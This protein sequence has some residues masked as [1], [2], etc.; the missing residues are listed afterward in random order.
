[1]KTLLTMLLF[2]SSLQVA[3][4][5]EDMYGMYDKDGK[6]RKMIEQ[7]ERMRQRSE[8]AENDEHDKKMRILVVSL[9]I[10]LVPVVVVGRMVVSR[11]TWKENPKKTIQA[12]AITLAGGAALF[13]FNYGWFYLKYLHE[14]IFK[15][16]FSLAVILLLIGIGIYVVRHKK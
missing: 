2:L 8:E 7:V 16:L 14:E 9:L 6:H 1:M 3:P 10:G 11:Q 13:A 12:M 4:S 15:L 5:P